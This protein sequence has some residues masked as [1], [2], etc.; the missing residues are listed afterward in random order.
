[1]DV[2]YS[3]QGILFEWDADK[4]AANVAKHGISFEAAC[5]AFFDPFVVVTDEEIVGDEAR[6]TIVGMT[7]R[8]K[9]LCVIYTVRIAE[10]YRIISA[11]EATP[12]E[13]QDYEGQ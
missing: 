4:A 2:E 8:W 1:M 7:L 11:R 5:E 10:R 9:V 6:D 3:C 13:R 12:T